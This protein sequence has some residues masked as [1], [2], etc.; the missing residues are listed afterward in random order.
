MRTR[1]SFDY[2]C[3]LTSLPCRF[4]VE[5]QTF[6]VNIF[7]GEVPESCCTWEAAESRIGI[8]SIFG[9]ALFS[10]GSCS[11]CNE[12]AEQEETRL[13][14]GQVSITSALLDLIEERKVIG[15]EV[16]A[17]LEREHVSPYLKKALRWRVSTVSASL[18][19]TAL[20]LTAT[21]I[22]IRTPLDW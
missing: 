6:V 14:T 3:H 13:V 21:D 9:G 1:I 10:S 8:V 2:L 16:L 5:G 11:N 19:F 12:Q 7:L 22:D 4:A 15:G 18:T 17:S 20:L